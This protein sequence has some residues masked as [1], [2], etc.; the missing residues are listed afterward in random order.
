MSV[1]EGADEGPGVGRASLLLTSEIWSRVSSSSSTKSSTLV[2]TA[3]AQLTVVVAVVLLLYGERL[4]QRKS[5]GRGGDSEE[6]ERGMPAAREEEAK[7]R[8]KPRKVAE[9]A[10][11]YGLDSLRNL[12]RELER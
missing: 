3:S 6:G 9:G 10:R 1:G 4:G 11:T 2:A 12:R 5:G 7:L 8:K